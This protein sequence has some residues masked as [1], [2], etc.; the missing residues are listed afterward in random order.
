MR[1]HILSILSLIAF[2]I[3]PLSLSSQ[4]NFSLS[5]DANSL[6]NDQAVTSLNVSTNQ[7]VSI[8]LFGN[9]MQNARGVSAR[10]EY[11]ASQVT[12]Q[13]FDAGNLLPSDQVLVEY[14]QNPASVQISVVSFG[15]FATVNS[16]LVGT[17]CVLQGEAQPDI[18][19]FDSSSYLLFEFSGRI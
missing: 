6:A 19:F 17:I 3:Y 12:Y 16:G 11:D 9:G 10:F 15:D 2:L 13:G 18:G 8:Q 7:D 5:I 14:S 1:Q 4:N